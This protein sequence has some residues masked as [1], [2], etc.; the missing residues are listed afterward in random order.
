MMFITS[1]ILYTQPDN[2]RFKHLSIEQGLSQS[3]ANCIIQDNSGFIWIGTETG[4]NKYD[5]YTFTVYESHADNLNSLSNSYILSICK[6]RNGM[7]WVGTEKGL[8]RFDPGKDQFTR[9]LHDPDDP[10][11]ISHDRINSICEDGNGSVWVGTGKGLNRFDQQKQK[12]FRYFTYPDN[13]K[14]LSNNNVRSVYIDKSGVLW[15]GTYGGGLNRFDH[16]KEEFSCYK[17]VPDD[18]GSLS[19]DNV[20]SI[21]E[22]KSGILWIGTDGGLNRFD[23]EKK[24][25]FCYNNVPDDPN[26][27]SD[28]QVNV[29]YEDKTGVLWIGTGSGGLNIFDREKER[30][31]CYK[32]SPDNP[33]SLS[34]NRVI[35]IYEGNSGCLWFGT[36]GGGINIF[37]RETQKF[38]HYKTDPNNPNSLNDNMIWAIHEDRYGI[39]WIGTDVGGLNKFDRKRNTFTHYIHN[40]D[41]P[42]SISYNRVVRICEDRSGVLWIG[43]FR[44]LNTFNRETGQFIHYKFDPDDPYSLSDNRVICILEDQSE[45][46][47]IGTKG[48]GLNKFDRNTEKF[49]HYKFDPDDPYSLSNNKVYD[50]CMDRSGVLWVGTFGGGLNKFDMEKETF[51]RYQSDPDNPNSLS[52]NFIFSLHVDRSGI[53][54]IGTAYGGLNKLD[55]AGDNFISFTVKD[56][57]PDNTI[58]SILED[59]KGNLWMGT[60]RGIAK[61]NSKIKEFKNFDEKN[62]LQSNEFNAEVA[63]KSKNGEMFFGGI[64]GFNSF[65]PDSIQDNPFIPPIVITDFKI[66]NKPVPIGKM[67]DDRVIL[68]KPI[69]E[70]R[71]IQLSYKDNV[72][73]FEFSAL[74]YVAPDKNQYAYLV[75]GLEEEWNYAGNRRYVT[76]ANLNPGEY[77]FKVK[78]SNNDGVWN[79]EGTSVKITIVPPFWKTWWF[80]TLCI[81]LTISIIA[82]ILIHQIIRFKKQKEEDERKKLTELFSQVLEY[83]GDA[84]I[85]RINFDSGEYDYMGNGIKDITG[86]DPSEFTLSFWEKIVI[87]E[88]RTGDLTG[89]SLDEV[90]QRVRNGKIDRWVVDIKIR[91]KTGEIAWIRDM[92]TAL[93]DQLG[94]CYEFFG[95]IFD[96]TDRKL[97]EQ[98]LTRLSEELTIQKQVLEDRVWERTK[99][100]IG[101][102]RDLVKE[103]GEHKKSLKALEEEKSYL[104]NLF[105]SAPE[106]ILL[107]DENGIVLRVNKEFTKIFGYTQDEAVGQHIDDLIAPEELREEAESFT[108]RT[109]ES[110]KFSFESIRKRKDGKRIH[111]SVLISPTIIND[112]LV[113]GYG[114][115]RDITK[116]KEAEMEKRELEEQLQHSQKMEAIGLLAGGVAHDFN[117]ML[118][119]ISGFSEMIKGKFADENQELKRYNNRIFEAAKSSADLISKLLAFARKGKYKID[120]VNVNSV[121]KTVIGILEH[122]IDKRITIIQQLNAENAIVIGDDTQLENAVVNIA[123]NA[124]DAMPAGGELKFTTDIVHLD[125]KY[126][127]RHSSR[128]TPGPCLQITIA[129]TGTGISEDTMKKI[130]EPF[131]TTKEP[132]KGTGLGLAS[133]FG[134]IKNHKGIINVTSKVG[135]GTTFIIHL[136]IAENPINGADDITE[137][138]QKGSGRVLIIDDEEPVR[139]I[140]TEMLID[141]G[142][143]TA[144]C[145]NGEEAVEYYKQHFYEIDLVVIDLMMPK[146]DGH[147]CFIEL[148]KINPGIKA[149]VSSGYSADGGVS[150]ILSEGALGFIQK[151]FEENE[152]SRV[153]YKA[154]NGD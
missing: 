136:P 44:G 134:T 124:L 2:I 75:E 36:R 9:Y 16:E 23:P 94:N 51:K 22:D 103:M 84:A 98:K 41:D 108:K 135:K 14:N 69:T 137:E 90:Y 7:F 110:N 38:I 148:K 37:N 79:E 120:E 125:N 18:P 71:E 132:G 127:K 46:L 121:I 105:D 42:K 114:I 58:Y 25:F 141:L 144:T 15:I 102:N 33:N 45:V 70:T 11:S 140:F 99:D 153:V 32:N 101:A 68:E 53:V 95:I 19:N 20:L 133:V 50:I 63:Y 131:F 91:T 26:S 123:V 21:Y 27:I 104:D 86:Y 113:G 31:V 61:F 48:G 13:P 35:S 126:I 106:A 116:H 8:N 28:N 129:D 112:R 49:I 111:V 115:Y 152:L 93:R 76:Y 34:H 29:I 146:L 24:Q 56:G 1:K 60:N 119:V 47:W 54:W 139:D 57:L 85:Y 10:Y 117:N 66:F 5:G 147:D 59:D 65:F 154:I 92:T 72:F 138:I 97:A 62:G 52:D 74:H 40:P 83:G 118:A 96:I 100:L 78:G 109:L 145:E 12:F 128:I 81:I 73:S 107:I 82:A 149:I 130:F 17:N 150:K 87:E 64:N 30:F 39:F 122:S 88:E 77:V 3:Y 55:P 89:L 4:L 142:Y 6:D 151:P 43:T 67:A 80:Y 143:T